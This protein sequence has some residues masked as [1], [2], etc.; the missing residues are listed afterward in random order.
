[1]LT[2]MT[3]PVRLLGGLNHS[4]SY[5]KATLPSKI[6]GRALK[7]N[8]ETKP[9]DIEE[10]FLRDIGITVKAQS[11]M[12]LDSYIRFMKMA[13]KCL[14]IEI[15]QELFLN[16]EVREWVILKSPFKYKK[17]M[18]K[19][20]LKTHGRLLT[21]EKITGITA[22]IYIEYVQRNIPAGVS[23]SVR[24]VEMDRLPHIITKSLMQ[25]R[26]MEEVKE[27]DDKQRAADAAAQQ[28]SFQRFR[29]K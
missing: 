3:L 25:N 27:E 19:Y 15:Y 16:P 2:R 8:A 14:N 23:M 9:P 18:V 5:S 4:L 29:K 6:R 22:D 12:V 24:K 11:S 26:T 13:A 10:I 28:D 7:E 17:H 21:F 1:M 20:R